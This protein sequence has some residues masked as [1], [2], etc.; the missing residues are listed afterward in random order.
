MIEDLELNEI[1]ASGGPLEPT[2][3]VDAYTVPALCPIL[4]DEN[5]R[6]AISY[7]RT[8]MGSGE[9][10]DR[11]LRLTGYI[12]ALNPAHY[13]VW[14]YRLDTL[15]RMGGDLGAE[16]AV[17]DGLAA[18]RGS[19]NYQLW[20]HR[21]QIVAR[22]PRDSLDL[23]RELSFLDAM[24]D[25]DAKNYH[26]WSYRQWL[27]KARPDCRVEEVD[28]V[29]ARVK[30]DV[31]N[32]SAWNHRFFL[33]FECE[34]GGD[35]EQKW[36]R[37][38]VERELGYVQD[39][40]TL[41]P[42]NAAS[43]NYLKGLLKRLELPFGTVREFAVYF[44]DSLPAL[45]FMLVVHQEAAEL[46]DARRVCLVLERRDVIRKKYWQYRASLIK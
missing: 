44:D 40:I 10:S 45:E 36:S 26:V 24:L 32:N 46:E 7:L 8:M 25:E 13:S 19:K 41:A 23:P 30:A 29:R 38:E 6:T 34:R 39:M 14:T 37:E 15:V 5:Y 18:T 43:W 16:L 1:I 35:G 22:L 28:R 27:V 21:E 42:D 20:Q 9:H 12:V 2:A 17:L 4:Y 31:Y 33:L 11:A 3:Q